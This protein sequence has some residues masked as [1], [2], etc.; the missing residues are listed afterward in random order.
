MA[1]AVELEQ[2]DEVETNRQTSRNMLIGQHVLLAVGEPADLLRV[3]VRHLWE[4][5]YRVNVF[6]G[7]DFACAR[8]A[9]SYFVQADDDGKIIAATPQ[10]VRKYVGRAAVP[11]RLPTGSGTCG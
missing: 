4:Q 2:F 9:N 5:R 1:K 3:Q 7:P 10:L 11:G 8:V 6:V